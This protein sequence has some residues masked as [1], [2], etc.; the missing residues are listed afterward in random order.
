MLA[1]SISC[2]FLPRT[3]G[4]ERLGRL[5]GRCIIVSEEGLERVN[6]L[7]ATLGNLF[8]LSVVGCRDTRGIGAIV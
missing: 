3:S 7:I 1:V 8:F 4:L 6:A 2:F 5:L